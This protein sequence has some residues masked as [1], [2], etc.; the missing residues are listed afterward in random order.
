M[1]YKYIEYKDGKEV[2]VKQ[3]INEQHSWML[4]NSMKRRISQSSVNK[5]DQNDWT[6]TGISATTMSNLQLVLK[7]SKIYELKKQVGRTLSEDGKTGIAI[8]VKDGKP[9]LQ[10]MDV[11]YLETEMYEIS[12]VEAN[13]GKY[14]N[15]DGLEMSLPVSVA[16]EIDKRG[17]VIKKEFVTLEGNTKKVLS[18]FK[19]PKGIKRIPFVLMKNNADGLGDIDNVGMWDAIKQLNFFASDFGVEWSVSR[20]LWTDR[21]AFADQDLESVVTDNSRFIKRKSIKSKLQEASEPISLGSQSILV[22]KEAIDFV[23]EKILEYTFT[24]KKSDS[25]GT[26]KFNKEISMFNQ[27]ASE[28]LE[29]KRMQRDS[30]YTELISKLIEVMSFLKLAVATEI[31]TIAVAINLSTLEEGIVKEAEGIEEQPTVNESEEEDE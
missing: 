12:Y 6:I 26:N 18:S 21:E 22:L 31:D 20:T 25:S 14:Y 4:G 7:C 16:F 27:D 17:R 3:K 9:Y 1:G 30:D 10:Q 8:L 11:T 19:Y 24:A 28:Y 5:I 23:E 13:T 2:T 29:A 15:E